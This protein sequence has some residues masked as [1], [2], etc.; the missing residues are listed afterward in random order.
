MKY[1]GKHYTPFI[2]VQ[3]WQGDPL[4]PLKTLRFSRVSL[5]FLADPFFEKNRGQG[6]FRLFVNSWG[7]E[8]KW[9]DFRIWAV[10]GQLGKDVDDLTDEE[11]CYV[12]EKV[13]EIAGEV[14]TNVIMQGQ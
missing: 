11:I 2:G 3:F 8:L 1:M 10:A 5:F 6:N 14:G 9:K 12:V 13:A 4:K 7:K